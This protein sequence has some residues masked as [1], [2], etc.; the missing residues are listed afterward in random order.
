MGRL[1]G[2][3]VPALR[4]GSGVETKSI[5]WDGFDTI[6]IDTQPGQAWYHAGDLVFRRNGTEMLRLAGVSRP[7]VFRRCCVESQQ[8]Y[9]SVKRTLEGQA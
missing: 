5:E 8:S 6:D 3:P 7:A 2:I 1:F 4:F 9:V